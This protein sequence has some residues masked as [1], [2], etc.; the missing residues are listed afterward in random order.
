MTTKTLNGYV[1]GKVRDDAMSIYINRQNELQVHLQL[2]SNAP[3][4]YKHEGHLCAFANSLTPLGFNDS[5]YLTDEKRV[6]NA[7]D[8]FDEQV[9]LFEIVPNGQHFNVANIDMRLE[10]PQMADQYVSIPLYREAQHGSLAEIVAKLSVNSRIGNNEYVSTDSDD[11]PSHI[12]Y[13]AADR[14]V[15]A[16]GLLDMQEHQQAGF[17]YRLKDNK[18]RM[19]KLSQ[20]T[21]LDMFLYEGVAFEPAETEVIIQDLLLQEQPLSKEEVEN[22]ATQTAIEETVTAVKAV[23]HIVQNSA[24]E[25][26]FMQHFVALTQQQNLQ[27]APRDLYHF[28]TA[29]KAGGLI[30]LGGMSGTGK[31]R[32]VTAYAQA[33]GLMHSQYSFIPVSPAWLDEQDLLG[34]ADVD[35]GQYV[36][37]A[38]SVVTLL[39]EAADNP[40]KTYIVCFDEMNL[41]KIE[42]YFAQFLSVLELD[43]TDSNRAIRLYNEQLTGRIKNHAQY[44]ATIP[45]GRN[46]IFVGTVNFDESTHRLSNKVLDR[47]TMIQLSQQDFMSMH[48]G[49]E[50]AQQ[51]MNV[52]YSLTDW[53]IY[54][55]TKGLEDYE[56][57][58]LWDVHHEMYRQSESLGFGPRTVKQI[59]HYMLQYSPVIAAQMTRGEALDEQFVSRILPKLR[60]DESLLTPL[61][62]TYEHEQ[63]VD[64]KLIELLDVY[65]FLSDFKKTRA[66]IVAKAKELTRYGYCL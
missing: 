66:K 26:Q 53:A 16:L 25:G 22:F 57:S 36:P 31:S 47:A 65:T 6:Q 14:N 64:S 62:G 43:A 7:Y 56:L 28:H 61:V 49:S 44:P 33:L 35:N 30:I 51:V 41:A 18:L 15:W 27:Y 39:K 12:L 59:N 9:L 40:N 13:E 5:F 52:H 11:Y 38:N 46:I 19:T 20:Q 45:L 42:H 37:A 60:G 50:R 23:Q 24:S 1:L 32:L 63:V 3:K 2:L 17:R 48:F 8:F 4:S 10:K 34:Y 58:L 55:E 21:L 54:T 29:M